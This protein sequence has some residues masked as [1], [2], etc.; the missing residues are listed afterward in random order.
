MELNEELKC[1]VVDALEDVKAIDQV[2]KFLTKKYSKVE[3]GT[4]G[5]N[6]FKLRESKNSDHHGEYMLLENITTSLGTRIGLKLSL[7]F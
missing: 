1:L 2:L 4:N 7:P 6:W 5:T 3:F